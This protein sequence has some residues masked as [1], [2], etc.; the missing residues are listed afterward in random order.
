MPL[1]SLSQLCSPGVVLPPDA[2]QPSTLV[3]RR[4]SR[5][6]FT[7]I[8]VM[9]V[10]VIIAVAS[11]VALPSFMRSFRGAKMKV[12]VRTVTMA[13]RL[14]RSTAVLQNQ[15]MALLFF[16]ESSE[17]EMVHIETPSGR[18]EQSKFVNERDDRRVSGMLGHDE[19]ESALDAEVPPTIS[20]TLVREL[21]EGVRITDIEIQDEQG[22][23]GGN[24]WVNFYPNGM[25]DKYVV[26]LKD[27]DNKEVEVS[28][29]PI[30][31]KVSIDYL[32]Q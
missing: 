15:H 22:D 18:G 24:V 8:E 20:Q 7:M 27:E 26:R 13:S 21:P 23:F 1:R 3:S 4:S 31:G 9:V 14:A 19:D 32:G 16:P 30:S 11:A 10:V 2:R 17:I 28:V 12:G 5:R 25:S 29:D 6:G